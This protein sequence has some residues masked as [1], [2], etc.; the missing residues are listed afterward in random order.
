MSGASSSRYFPAIAL[1]L[2]ASIAFVAT[3]G[4]ILIVI[5]VVA[6]AVGSFFAGRKAAP[7]EQAV[8]WRSVSGAG[9]LTPSAVCRPADR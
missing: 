2:K 6:V 7:Q 4:L 1:G 3:A 8:Y 9:C 5:L